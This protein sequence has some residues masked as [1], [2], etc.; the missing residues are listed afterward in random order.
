MSY[1]ADQRIR[2]GP[3][4]LALVFLMTAMAYSASGPSLASATY[5]SKPEIACGP[6][7]LLMFLKMCGREPDV[8]A[9]RALPCDDEGMSLLQMRDFCDTSGLQTEVR[10]FSVDEIDRMPLPAVWQLHGGLQQHFCVV[11]RS[12]LKGLSALDGTTG[13]HFRIHNDRIA[14]F[15]SQYALV[16]RLDL[17]QRFTIAAQSP[18]TVRT[19]CILAI[20]IWLVLRMLL[21]GRKKPAIV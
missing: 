15:F 7:S 13:R 3:L 19:L 18:P 5:A 1:S 8:G 11:Y 2:K 10:Y 4:E 20:T 16:P 21:R 6:N 17:T 14:G 9:I 12:G